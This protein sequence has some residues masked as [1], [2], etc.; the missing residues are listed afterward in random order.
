VSSVKRI[1]K[2]VRVYDV[3][4]PEGHHFIANSVVSHNTFM[5]AMVC[6]KLHTKTLIIAHQREWLEN[7]METFI[8]SD[9]AKAMTDIKKRRVGFC[10]TI[11]DFESKD[12][13]F[14]TFQQFFNKN[15]QVVLKK[16]VG[17]FGLVIFDEVHQA[18]ATVSARVLSAF[19]A[20]Y[21]L[22]LSGSTARKDCLAPGTMIS[23]PL[24][25]KPVE[26]LKIGD[27][28][29][30]F[31]HQAKKVEIKEITDTWSVRKAKRL[32]ITFESGIVIYCSTCERFA[33]GP[34]KIYEEARKLSVGE[35]VW[36]L[37]QK[38]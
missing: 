14:A 2:P 25:A 8:G 4:V 13:C 15:G 29:Y 33:T 22:G 5:G 26:E 36:R 30:S 21:R 1:R 16:I 32:K 34:T 28:V 12:V 6:R 3:E 11:E 18:P 20:R 23:T 27:E 7:F 38:E 37:P 35:V 31:N 17:M 9:S 19:K 10:K 24:G